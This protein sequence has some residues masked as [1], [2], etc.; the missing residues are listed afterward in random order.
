M[1]SKGKQSA[2]N[3]AGSA[4]RKITIGGKSYPCR[5]TMGAM[6]RFKRATG[7]DVAKLDGDNMEELMIFLHSCLSSACKVDGVEFD[8]TMEDMADQM[9]PDDINEFYGAMNSGDESKKKMPTPA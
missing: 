5:V 6:L 3:G 9:T 8:M 2:G 7:K 1:A 4:L